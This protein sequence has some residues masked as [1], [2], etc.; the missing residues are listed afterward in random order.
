[1]DI[2]NDPSTDSLRDVKIIFRK[3]DNTDYIQQYKVVYLVQPSAFDLDSDNIP[4]QLDDNPWLAEK[5]VNRAVELATR[6]YRENT[7]QNQVM[8]NKRS[9]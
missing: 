5:I 2:N 1:L 9:E 8:L 6:D 3:S 7:L 4:I